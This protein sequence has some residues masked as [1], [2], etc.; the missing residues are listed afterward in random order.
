MSRTSPYYTP[1]V[2]LITGASAGIG[3]ATARALL[4]AGYEVFGTCRR[5]PERR[6]DGIQYLQCNVTSDESISAVVAEVLRASQR[7]DLL[8]NNAGSGLVAG[9]QTPSIQQLQGLFEVNF[10]GAVR[11]AQAVL[12]AMRRQRAGR[13]VSLSAVLGATPSPHSALYASTKQEMEGY[14]ESLD[15]GVRAFGIRSVLV[16][17]A[18]SRSALDGRRVPA[19]RPLDDGVQA[20]RHAQAHRHTA[21]QTAE[22]SETVAAVVLKAAQELHPQLRYTAGDVARRISLLRRFVPAG[23]FD[24]SLRW[25]LGL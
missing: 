21:M 22:M 10:L 18:Y 2:A 5:T 15:H 12:P 20:R 11:M 17:P 25:Q 7:I 8:V 14:F 3:E 19:D 9:A 23:A 13:I 1:R 4:A 6:I 16:E 24:Q